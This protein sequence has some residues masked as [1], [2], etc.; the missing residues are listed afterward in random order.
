M[1]VI[2]NK[3]YEHLW[4]G[5]KIRYLSLAYMMCVSSIKVELKVIG[6]QI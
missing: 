3:F 1:H 5:A 2:T 6:S 4:M